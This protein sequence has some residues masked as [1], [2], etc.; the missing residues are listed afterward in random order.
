[1]N[2][3]KQNTYLL[4]ILVLIGMGLILILLRSLES[5]LYGSGVCNK[6]QETRL[7][8]NNVQP[9]EYSTIG[10]LLNSQD[11][12]HAIIE[13]ASTW[14]CLPHG[15]WFRIGFDPFHKD[16]IVRG[17]ILQPYK[18]KN[19]TIWI[20]IQHQYKGLN[21][22]NLGIDVTVFFN[23][24]PDRIFIP[25]EAITWFDDPTYDFLLKPYANE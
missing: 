13:E 18:E 6:V 12:I 14:P 25:F 9:I 4:S 22:T 3:I 8:K 17:D 20:H 23:G 1:M 2:F 16:V 10:E 5:N 7:V 19:E 11:K 21:A 24:K 15:H